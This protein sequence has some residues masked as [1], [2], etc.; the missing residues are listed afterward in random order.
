MAIVTDDSLSVYSM[1]ERACI[2]PFPEVTVSRNRKI[3]WDEAFGNFFSL[4]VIV[5]K[6]REITER[7]VAVRT[8][9]DL[10]AYTPG[11][12]NRVLVSIDALHREMVLQLKEIGVKWMAQRSREDRVDPICLLKQVQRNDPSIRTDCLL[13]RMCPYLHYRSIDSHREWISCRGYRDRMVLGGRRLHEVCETL[14]HRHCEY[15]L[16]PRT[17]I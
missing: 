17:R 15:L 6:S 3:C 16:H 13:D 10:L 14:E 8:C 5:C 2:C 1:D 12:Q 9:R 7:Q 11:S 4:I